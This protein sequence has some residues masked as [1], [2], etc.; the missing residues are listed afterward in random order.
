MANAQI[1]KLSFTKMRSVFFF[2]L[3]FI[4]LF[5]FLYL[6]Q[7]FFYPVFWAAILAI[8]FYPVY[9]GL[10]NITKMPG[11]SSI[12]S[13]LIVIV[14]IFLP[15]SLIITLILHQSFT[16]YQSVASGDWFLIRVQGVADWLENTPI[17][18]YIE[19]ITDNWAATAADATKAITIFLFNNLKS[20]TQNSVSFIF[21]LFLTL[22]TLF[23][24]FRDGERLL[25]RLQHLSP[26]GDSHE[27]ALYDQF[28]S[29]ARA[30]LKSTFI[31]GGIQGILGGILFWITGVEGAVIWAVIMFLLSL[32]P[33]LGT[34][35]VWLPVGVIMLVIG[36][37]WQGITILLVGALVISTIDNLL[38]PP[39]VGKDIQMPPLLVL[40]S[41]LG[42]IVLFGISGFVIGPVVTSLFLAII[43]IY[44]SYYLREL[45]QNE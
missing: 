6:M 40:F 33:G 35:L 22:Y 45:K 3:V 36:N 23:F 28:T 27:R 38:R 32:V 42:G 29:T 4:L 31:V 44:D 39:L 9:N 24:F 20:I 11:I 26:L 13:I 25:K 19:S 10:R 14:S 12:L 17:A 2:S 5:A 8:M 43:S 15:L 34:F 37:V 7:P 16:L 30:T 41:T 18:P 1:G 21:M